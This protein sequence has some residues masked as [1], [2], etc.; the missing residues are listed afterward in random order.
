M[1]QLKSVSWQELFKKIFMNGGKFTRLDLALDDIATKD[2]DLYFKVSTLERK[3]K[4]GLCKSKMKRARHIEE[5]DIGNGEVGGQTLYFGQPSSRIQVRFYEKNYERIAAGYEIKEDIIGWNRTELQ[6]R[7]QRAD[8]T[9][10]LIA[11]GEMEL[12]KIIAGLLK[13]YISFISEKQTDTNKS[14]QKVAKFW[15]KFLGDIEPL[16]IAEK[17]PDQT[18][19]RKMS[20]LDHSV[21]KSFAAVFYANGS[22]LDKVGEFINEGLQKLDDNDLLMIE[23]YINQRKKEKDFLEKMAKKNRPSGQEGQ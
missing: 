16:K 22:D 1:E 4:R 7:K 6:L 10:G 2:R 18:I 5:I 15:D 17:A 9:A 8:K 14:R 3:L 11:S 19:E 13:H 21:Q 20:W 12:G 23:D